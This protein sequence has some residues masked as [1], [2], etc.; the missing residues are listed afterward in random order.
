MR[1]KQRASG[2]IVAIK[3]VPTGERRR[4]AEFLATLLHGRPKQSIEP[5]LPTNFTIRVT[6]EARRQQAK[7]WGG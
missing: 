7:G 6:G 4:A 3:R 2:A 5:D 1:G